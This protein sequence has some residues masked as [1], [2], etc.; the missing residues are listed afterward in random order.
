[1]GNSSELADNHYDL[2]VIKNSVA[3]V[4][5]LDEA[6]PRVAKAIVESYIDG[7]EYSHGTYV[8]YVET[9]TRFSILYP[10]NIIR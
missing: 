7:L 8:P 5:Y 2:K 3:R 6:P 10:F 9:P 4:D 1:M